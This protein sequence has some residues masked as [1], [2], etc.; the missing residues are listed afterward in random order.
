MSTLKLGILREGKIPH[1]KRVAITPQQGAE[2]VALFPEVDLRIQPCE[3]RCY[4]NDEY[5]AF[6]LNLLEDLSDCDILVG[7]KEVQKADL[8]AGKKYV[9]FS[10]TIKKQAHNREMLREI[11]R[12]K[13]TLIDYECLTDKDGNRILGFGRY[14]GIIGAY[15][16]LLGYGKKYDLFHLKPANDCRDRIELDEELKRVRL[17]NIKIIVTGGG[18]VANGALETLGALKIRKVTPYEFYNYSF[19]EPVYT[20]L[21][22]KDYHVSKDGSPWSNE[23]FYA[24]PEDFKSTFQKFLPHCDLLIHC[25]FWSPDAPVLFT[26]NDMKNFTDFRVSVIAD[27][28]CDINGSIPSTVRAS[29]IDKPFY[30]FNPVS[31]KEDVPFSRNTITVMAVDN[32]PC[33][34]PRD[35]SEDFG[36]SLIDR[37]FPALFGNDR[38]GIIERATIAKDGKLSP[39]FLYLSDYIS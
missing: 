27:V 37:V 11:I 19:R 22:S 1:D 15:S 6:G 16:G 4:S 35:S 36:K 14:A 29:S 23:N 7:I 34:L 2:L 8:I 12:K 18:R 3:Y 28:T 39:R 38:N 17:P 9:F 5:R 21:H 25:A 24:H 13:I 26:L 31:Q 32:L 30:G 33:E 10:H 20:Q